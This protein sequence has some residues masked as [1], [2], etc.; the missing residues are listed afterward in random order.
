MSVEQGWQ[1]FCYKTSYRNFADFWAFMV[2]VGQIVEASVSQ[3]GFFAD[4][5]SK[6]AFRPKDATVERHML[7]LSTWAWRRLCDMLS[8]RVSRDGMGS[9]SWQGHWTAAD[10][11]ADFLR[12]L[13]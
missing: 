1:F 6:H 9:S 13:A 3:S 10:F 2:W 7:S 4:S 8:A 11:S 5:K 12:I